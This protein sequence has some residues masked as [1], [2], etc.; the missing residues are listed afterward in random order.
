MRET[1][2]TFQP[3][4]G[5]SKRSRSCS[6]KVYSRREKRETKKKKERKEE[7]EREKK[8]EKEGERAQLYTD[9][10][11]RVASGHVLCELFV[12]K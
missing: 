2:E 4:A 3:S 12:K 1:H 5:E 7:M 9:K 11:R 10:L 8:R 6:I